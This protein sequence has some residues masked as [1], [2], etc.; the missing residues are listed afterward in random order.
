MVMRSE[1]FMEEAYSDIPADAT[2]LCEELHS[3]SFGS[4]HSN[5]SVSIGRALARQQGQAG[6]VTGLGGAEDR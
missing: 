6:E 2:Y 4:P 1:A 5:R 3:P